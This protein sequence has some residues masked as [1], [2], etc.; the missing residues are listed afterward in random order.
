MVY[1]NPQITLGLWELM[2]TEQWDALER[3]LRPV[4][5]L[6]DFLATHFAPK[7]FTDNRMGGV[8]TRFLAMALHNRGPYRSATQQDVDEFRAWC[9]THFPEMLTLRGRAGLS[10]WAE[11]NY[12]FMA[13]ID[14]V[15]HRPVLPIRV[16]RDRPCAL[17]CANL[18]VLSVSQ[19]ESSWRRSRR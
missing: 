12:R 11:K 1:W 8:A 19:W 13:P 7:G 16:G 9:R 2:K 17:P 14:I 10:G 3:E 4:I 5:A 18:C 15:A 6:H